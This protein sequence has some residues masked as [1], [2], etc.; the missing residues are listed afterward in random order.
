MKY[1]DF[2]EALRC[3]KFIEERGFIIRPHASG[4]YCLRPNLNYEE[5]RHFGFLND[6]TLFLFTEIGEAHSFAE[7]WDSFSQYSKLAKQ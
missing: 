2:Q 4:G 1:E 6:A 3:V 5:M 7:G